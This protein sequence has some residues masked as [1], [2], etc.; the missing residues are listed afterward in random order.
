VDVTPAAAPDQPTPTL[1]ERRLAVLSFVKS[2]FATTGQTP[3]Q[4]EIGKHFDMTPTAAHFHVHALVK[5]GLL[6]IQP[7][8]PRGIRLKE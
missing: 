3:T 2:H 8:V 1:S 5:M 4:G 7:H 6:S